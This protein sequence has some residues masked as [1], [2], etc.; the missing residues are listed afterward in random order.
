MTCFWP[1]TGEGFEAEKVVQLIDEEATTANITR[2]LR[3]FLKKPAK[4]DIVL[5]YFA[6]H[7]A[8]DIDRPDIL[9]LLT[10]DTH[11][12]DVSG[13]APADERN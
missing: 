8:P 5:L 4:E 11:P 2:A 12:A 10:H 9:Y 6:C 13:I 3:S 1:P 7:G